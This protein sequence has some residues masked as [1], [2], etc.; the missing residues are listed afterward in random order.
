M[1]GVIVLW[2]RAWSVT[3]RV[4]TRDFLQGINVMVSWKEKEV[5]VCRNVLMTRKRT[6]MAN[7]TSIST[8]DRPRLWPHTS[9]RYRGF[10]SH[11]VRS[12]R[13]E[14][15]TPSR[16]GIHNLQEDDLI[17]PMWAVRF[18]GFWSNYAYMSYDHSLSSSQCCSRT[19]NKRK[20]AHM[21]DLRSV[22]WWA[23][24]SLFLDKLLSRFVYFPGTK[25]HATMNACLHL[26]LFL[27]SLFHVS[28]A[29]LMLQLWQ[30]LIQ[31]L[32]NAQK[33]S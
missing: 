9:R 17:V 33:E 21:L 26:G 3:W 14:P 30:E 28:A 12:R 29:H 31:V 22:A 4:S 1:H 5:K 13:T 10:D 32:T 23:W 20:Y 2:T 15:N 11:F 24:F 19:V 6:I 8:V 25:I 18:T 27:S 16:T 7:K